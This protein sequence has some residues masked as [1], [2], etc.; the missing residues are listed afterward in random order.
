MKK[1]FIISS[2]ISVSL[3]V[4]T[5]PTTFTAN[6]IGNNSNISIQNTS[7]I[8]SGTLL[9]TVGVTYRSHVQNIGWQPWVSNGQEAGTDGQSLRVESLNIKLLNA[10]AGAKIDYQAH[11]QN[12]GW[13]DWVSDGE[14]IGTD[15]QSLRVEALKIKL[16]NMPEYSIQYQVHVQN[17]GWQDWVSDGQEA[18]T[19]GQSLRIEAIRIKI[20]P[21]TNVV[22]VTYRG[23]VQNIGWQSWVRDG[24]EAGTD[25]QGLRVEALNIK[26]LN[27][28]A[29]AKIDYKAHVQNVGWQDWVSDGEE[30]GTDGQ[31]LRVEALKIKLENMPGYSV[32]YQTHVQNIGWQDWVS[33]GQE[34]GT[35]GKSLR[36]EAIRIRIVPEVNNIG[37]NSISLN[38]TTDTLTVGNTD[39]LIATV[40]PN[41][42]TNKA[43]IWTSSDTKIATVDTTGK[44]TAVGAGIAIITVTTTDGNKTASCIIVNNPIFNVQ[45][46]VL[47]KT[48][49]T[50]KVG[51]TDTLLA[52]I[53]PTNATNAS[54]NWTSSNTK[55]VTV[56]NTGKVTAVNAGT[57]TI[58]VTTVDGN[59]TA[60]CTITAPPVNVSSIS[61]NKDKD[62]LSEGNSDTLTATIVPS[63][64][65]NKTITWS[66]SD[67]KIA[68]VNSAGKIT[69]VSDGIAIISA[70][71]VDGNKTASCTV[72]VNLVTF[73]DKNL[74]K[75]IRNTINKPTGFLYKSDMAKITVLA[76]NSYSNDSRISDLSGIEN[77]SN[78]QTLS[79]KWNSIKNID[80]LKGLTK[81]QNIDL[82][83]NYNGLI[84]INV[85]KTLTNLKTLYLISS[86]TSGDRQELINALPN[87]EIYFSLPEPIHKN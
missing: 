62:Y 29:G 37:V 69:A 56:D 7:I 78:L 82:S 15:G 65:T 68:T 39:T 34:A 77:L 14:E 28:P 73:K 8:N 60:S 84:D 76:G 48:T 12:L 46:V 42:A 36:I 74:E 70:A 85:L 72:V 45:S 26:L 55:I 1:N 9:N 79:L 49:D 53:T 75:V 2:L 50:I 71:T 47:N 19:D 27:A 57:A 20:V 6:A 59:K 67:N 87:C 51:N 17:V 10:P 3:L 30:V 40:S 61:L 44:V 41:N 66:S 23:H 32:Q 31:S 83:Y 58:T 63:N 81:I 13:Q 22:G 52:S 18:G 64:A 86:P 35:D 4:S 80:S 21:K 54:V 24:Q 11:V 33:D 5:L 25:G 43:V 16:E 38:K